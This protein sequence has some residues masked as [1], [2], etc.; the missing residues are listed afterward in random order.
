[1]KIDIRKQLRKARR[2]L[3][4]AEHARR[5]NRA[6][7][8][9]TRLAAFKAGSRI[10]VYLPFDREVDTSVL[11]RAAQRRG[12]KVYVPVVAD[13]RHRRLR[14]Q[15]LSGKTRRGTY[16]IAVPHRDGRALGSR[17]FNL[18]VVPLVGLDR[19]GRRLGMG[20]GFYDRALGFRR[21]RRHW[22]GPCLVGLAF[23]CQRADTVTADPWDVR[24]DWAATESGLAKFRA[25]VR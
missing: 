22:G 14:F 10:A 6:A 5:S 25:A 13:V 11:L 1:M 20:G 3:S 8:G 12:V 18:I 21:V 9:V 24:L 2:S 17:W 19:E 16:G 15:P 4:P 23:D 7:A